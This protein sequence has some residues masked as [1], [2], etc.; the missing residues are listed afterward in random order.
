M[1]KSLVCYTLNIVVE[2]FGLC[3][4]DK[5]TTVFKH[6]LQLQESIRLITMTRCQLII[7]CPQV[8]LSL[9]QLHRSLRNTP[10]ITHPSFGI[11]LHSFYLYAQDCCCYMFNEA[12]ECGY[13]FNI[14]SVNPLQ[15]MCF[16][17]DL[18]WP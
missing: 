10:N 18:L 11:H 13:F 8:M 17:C 6:V 5:V 3:P 9:L 15:C 16:S 1:T 12:H 2:S 14:K 4:M 7:I